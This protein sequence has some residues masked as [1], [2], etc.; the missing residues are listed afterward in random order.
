MYK[1]WEVIY[2]RPPRVDKNTQ[3][4]NSEDME[5]TNIRLIVGK[6]KMRKALT[7]SK[8]GYKAKKKRKYK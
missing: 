8:V 1:L 3:F 4:A 2:E 5:Y 7:W 6:K